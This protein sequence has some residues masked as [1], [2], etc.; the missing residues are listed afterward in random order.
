MPPQ[1]VRSCGAPSL[2][3]ISCPSTVCSL[4]AAYRIC[5][6]ACLP[7]YRRKC[8]VSLLALLPSASPPEI[9]LGPLR[10]APRTPSSGPFFSLGGARRRRLAK[11]FHGRAAVVPPSVRISACRR[12]GETVRSQ[13]RAGWQAGWIQVRSPWLRPRDGRVPR[14][15]GGVCVSH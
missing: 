5:P 7:A 4:G 9:C 12:L 11:V 2:D 10:Y 6:S 15:R 8:V 14:G 3:G 13:S 1:A